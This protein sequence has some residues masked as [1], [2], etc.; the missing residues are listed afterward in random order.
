MELIHENIFEVPSFRGTYSGDNDEILKI[1]LEVGR[2]NDNRR[3]QDQSS[4]KF[5][6]FE[7]P[8]DKFEKGTPVYELLNEIA[9]NL[10]HTL[11]FTSQYQASYIG[12]Y[13]PWTIVN[14]PG[15]QVFPHH[16]NIGPSDWACVYWS[17]YE[18]KSG[19]LEFYPLGMTVG[20]YPIMTCTPKVGDYLIF[21]GWIMHGVRQNCSDTERVSMSV[22]LKRH[23]NE[24]D[25]V[26]INPYEE[27]FISGNP[28]LENI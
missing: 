22:N 8:E 3:S 20:E 23:N 1:L 18:E 11:A 26:P 15:H 5:Q 10:R 12:W 9:D 17:K 6:D 2:N 13:P 4:I 28:S 24:A 25:V 16:H 14:G 19:D 21:P 7:L 27:T